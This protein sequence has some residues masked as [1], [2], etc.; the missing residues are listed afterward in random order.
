MSQNSPTSHKEKAGRDAS[1]G[2]VRAAN[3]LGICGNAEIVR[4]SG[5]SVSREGDADIGEGMGTGI[6]EMADFRFELLASGGP[7]A[8]I[9]EEFDAG[10]GV[11]EGEVA[12]AEAGEFAQSGIEQS[13]EMEG[14]TRRF[15]GEVAQGEREGW[16][17]EGEVLSDVL[18]ADGFEGV[19]DS[20]GE[21]FDG[22]GG[23]FVAVFEVDE[24]AAGDI[25][26]EP[27]AVLV[28]GGAGSRLD[29][30]DNPLFFIGR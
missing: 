16:R 2:G 24:E 29:G 28:A 26:R 22:D 8:G 3:C 12:D 27:P 19:A 9:G 17:L 13:E 23:A 1:L 5:A 15:R 20:G 18:E 11:G 4:R 21:V 6:Q 25:G 7:V 14:R 10:S 30:V